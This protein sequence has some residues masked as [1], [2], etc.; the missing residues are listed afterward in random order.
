M[1]FSCP[2]FSDVLIWLYLRGKIVENVMSNYEY[3]SFPLTDMELCMP[4]KP[5]VHIINAQYGKK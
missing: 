3:L 2:Y 1:G 5:I 4:Q